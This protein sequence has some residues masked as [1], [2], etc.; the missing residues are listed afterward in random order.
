MVQ[1]AGDKSYQG[2]KLIDLAAVKNAA[3]VVA[4]E[5]GQPV[6]QLPLQIWEEVLSQLDGLRGA[7]QPEDRVWLDLSSQSFAFWDNDEDAV[8]D[9]L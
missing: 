6:V 1:W 5:Q 9:S 3:R 4:D 2:V 8:Y 7:I